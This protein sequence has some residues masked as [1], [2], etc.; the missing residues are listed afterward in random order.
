MNV[1]EGSLGSPGGLVTRMRRA[2]WRGRK[3][4][5]SG[6]VFVLPFFL[7]FVL[8]T[9][10]ALVFGIYLSFTKWEIMGGAEFIG[11]ANYQEAIGDEM[12]RKA[13]LNT[14]RY[15]LII[16]PGITIVAFIFAF[17]VHSRASPS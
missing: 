10:G 16:V 8:F 5:W 17:F 14:F 2:T 7:F 13:F 1:A 9:A 15:V 11:L 4:N 12:V 3:I 6:Y